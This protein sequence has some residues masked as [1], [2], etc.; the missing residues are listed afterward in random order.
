MGFIY[1]IPTMFYG[2]GDVWLSQ[3]VDNENLFL[4]I[5][6]SHLYDTAKQ[7]WHSNIANTTYQTFKYIFGQ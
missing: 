2:F 5:L 6:T 3:G 7:N 4:S 1:K